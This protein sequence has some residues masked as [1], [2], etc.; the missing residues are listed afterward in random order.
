[1]V[2]GEI[3]DPM[4]HVL[5]LVPHLVVVQLEHIL[6][7]GNVITQRQNMMGNNVSE[8]VASHRPVH[9]QHTVQV[10]ICLFVCLLVFSATFNNISDI[11]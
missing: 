11:S 10:S 6:E 9:P 1:M 7:Q 5:F 8:V 4:E 2:S 3:G